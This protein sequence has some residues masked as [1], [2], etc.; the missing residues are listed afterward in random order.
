MSAKRLQDII[1]R[2]ENYLECWK[3]FNHYLGLARFKKFT[4]DD[5]NQFM[6]VK[7]VITQELELI[8]AVLDGSQV[9]RDDV[10]NLMT[11]VP[12]MRFLSESNE[13]VLRNIENQWHKLYITW[14]SV[15]GQMKVRQKQVENKGFF[16]V[17]V[18][19]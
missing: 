12:S 14:Q 13:G 7:S 8:L 6:E 10:H 18:G 3:Q 17:L 11:A 4:L 19:K 9:T 5:E 2:M 15:L 1:V 16:A